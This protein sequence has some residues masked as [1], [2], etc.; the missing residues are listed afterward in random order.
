[1]LDPIVW[2][3]LE[4]G[5][6][7][8]ALHQIT[9]IG[10]V[11]TL[12]DSTLQEIG[13]PFEAK[14]ALASGH[15][16]EDALKKQGYD[17]DVWI[18]EAVS[19]QVAIRAFID[20]IEPF[21]HDRV[22]KAGKRYQ[23]GHVA[24]YNIAFDAEFLRETSSRNGVWMP[25]TTWTGGMFDVLQFAKWTAVMTGAQ[26][27]NYQLETVC[28]FYGVPILGSAHDALVDVK[29]TV[30]LARALMMGW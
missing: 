2:V 20:W 18:K 19:V 1:M 7:D 9:Q 26:P 29:A 6:L 13:E 30:R 23:A 28:K 3:D 24:G 4:T 10:A 11:A 15:Y 17:K 21:R 5:G 27:E 25:L 16:E 22:N 8:P 14:V 12:G